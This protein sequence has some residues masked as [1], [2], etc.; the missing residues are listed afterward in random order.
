[1][2][3]F[4]DFCTLCQF[5]IAPRKFH[6]LLFPDYGYPYSIDEAELYAQYL[7]D[8]F[9]KH[10]LCV[11]NVDYVKLSA[12]EKRRLKEDVFIPMAIVVFRDVYNKLKD[13]IDNWYKNHPECLN[14]NKEIKEKQEPP[15][16][17][18]RKFNKKLQRKKKIK[19]KK[20]EKKESLA[21]QKRREKKIRRRNY[22]FANAWNEVAERFN[23]ECVPV[24][25][26]PKQKSPK[27]RRHDFD[28][29]FEEV[30]ASLQVNNNRKP[31]RIIVGETNVTNTKDTK[32]KNKK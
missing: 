19:P 5:Y 18:K 4:D 9:V 11:F 21:A 24:P 25:E 15:K 7:Y 28:S 29:I 30:M 16:P 1:M 27:E 31:R 3:R 8:R 13:R 26:L 12:E 10:R 6:A 23:R 2:F 22:D 17:K 14:G 20:P 32:I